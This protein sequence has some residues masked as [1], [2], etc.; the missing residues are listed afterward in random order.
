MD[1]IGEVLISPFSSRWQRGSWRNRPVVCGVGTKATNH[2]QIRGGEA[3]GVDGGTFYHNAFVLLRIYLFLFKI[4][5]SKKKF[6][7]FSL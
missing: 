4:K 2:G 6:V 3:G 1:C 7:L 5:C